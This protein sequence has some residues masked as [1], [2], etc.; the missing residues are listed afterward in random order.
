MNSRRSFLSKSALVG[1][2][3]IL[4]PQFSFSTDS[5]EGTLK[6]GL[7]GVGLRGTNHLK[8]LLLREDVRVEAICDIDPVRIDLNRELIREAGKE[9]PDSLVTQIRIIND[10]IQ[11]SVKH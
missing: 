10:W 6:V 4:A 7:I 9:E 5:V 1:S 3:L 2:G 8:N 11:S